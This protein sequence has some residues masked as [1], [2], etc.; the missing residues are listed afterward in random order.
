MDP[1]GVMGIPRWVIAAEAA[2]CIGCVPSGRPAGLSPHATLREVEEF[3]SIL[4]R[5]GVA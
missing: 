5:W 2:A 4:S 1:S 3:R